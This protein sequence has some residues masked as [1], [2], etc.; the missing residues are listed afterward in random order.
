M[1]DA[2]C[3]KV[4]TRTYNF[5]SEQEGV[6]RRKTS[7][8]HKLVHLQSELIAL[9]GEHYNLGVH[10]TPVDA[11]QVH[12]EIRRLMRERAELNILLKIGRPV[13]EV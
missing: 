12:A 1:H 4:S 13:T 2:N 10:Q 7:L 3:V 5:D 11:A 6:K 8:R 9:E